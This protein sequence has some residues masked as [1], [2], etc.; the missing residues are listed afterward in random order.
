MDSLDQ[1]I[2]PINIDDF[3]S[4][5]W[6]RMPLH[7]PGVAQKFA[8]FPGISELPAILSGRLTPGRWVSGPVSSAQASF[9][10]RTGKARNIHAVP[11]M[12]PDLFNAGASLCFSAVDHCHERLKRFVENVTSTIRFPGTIVTT[13][14]LTPPSSGSAMH[15]DSHHVFFMQVAGK[16]HWTI[17]NQPAW[18]DSP[19]NLQLST[20]D[21][22]NVKALL[23]AT[24]VVV[25][26]PEAVGTTELTL[27]A[28]DVLYLPPGFWHQARTSDSSSL[29]YTLGFMP[30]SPWHLL[31]AYLRRT[32][33]ECPSLRRDLRFAAQSGDGDTRDL[34]EAGIQ[35]LKKAVDGLTADNIES[36]FAEISSANGQ[37]KDYLTQA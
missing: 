10:D 8:R 13:C 1:L 21:D 11:S 2:A 33:L 37:L 28:G 25:R 22:V 20:L 31:V 12:W 14:Y 4:H 9:L 5:Y 3:F 7:I 30:L 15:I 35:K 27:N 24:G 16:K 17:S 32:A 26:R 19:I 34:I 18:E 23:D 6:Y 29:H 36:F